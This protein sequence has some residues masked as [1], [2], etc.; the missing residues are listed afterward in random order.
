MVRRWRGEW[1]Q[2]LPLKIHLLLCTLDYSIRSSQIYTILKIIPILLFSIVSIHLQLPIVSLL[3]ASLNLSYKAYRILPLD[4]NMILFKV[5]FKF[6]RLC[7]ILLFCHGKIPLFFGRGILTFYH[8]L[9]R[10][11]HFTS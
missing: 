4:H 3:N 11:F 10:L 8:M 6:Y 5:D 7:L 1:M 2:D 9:V